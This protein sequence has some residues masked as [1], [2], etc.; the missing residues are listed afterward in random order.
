M[1]YNELYDKTFAVLKD[2]LQFKK[3]KGLLHE[4]D[5]INKY[6]CMP[7]EKKAQAAARVHLKMLDVHASIMQFLKSK[8]I[9]VSDID[10]NELA[11]NYADPDYKF[12]F[13]DYRD[14]AVYECKMSQ[15]KHGYVSPQKAYYAFK[16][17]MASLTK[18]TLAYVTENST[19]EELK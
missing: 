2:N 16:A 8:G 14:G 7:I 13:T 9:D 18:H 11:A 4:I 12:E 6:A 17:Q 3:Y 10:I 15:M 19:M 1:E 5:W